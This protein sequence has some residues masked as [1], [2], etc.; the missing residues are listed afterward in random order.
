MLFR[1]ALDNAVA[2]QKPVLV[3]FWKP[4]WK[5]AVLDLTEVELPEVTDE[6]LASAAAGDGGYA[7]DYAP[8]ILYKAASA[9]LETKNPAAF[10]LLQKFQL[11]TEQQNEIA[12]LID[13]EAAMDP[14]AAAQQ[15]VS[16]NPDVVASW[17]S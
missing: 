6:C 5:H 4:H 2:D 17:T 13:G 3:Q 1:S 11:T 16:E 15:W 12:N 7:C 14:L 9:E 10:A 8:D